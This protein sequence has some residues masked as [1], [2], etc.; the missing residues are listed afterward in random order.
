[1]L[2]PEEHPTFTHPLV[3]RAIYDAMDVARREGLHA[4]AADMLATA[5]AAPARVATHLLAVA[6]RG[7]HAVVASLRAAAREATARGAP[8]AAATY[9]ARALDEPPADADRSAVTLELGLALAHSRPADS[10]P[11]LMQVIDTTDDDELLADAVLALSYV[12]LDSYA[13]VPTIALRAM[14]RIRDE[15][16]RRRVEAHYAMM[17][18]FRPDHYPAA[19]RML[20]GI[21]DRA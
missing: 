5:G 1:M 21:T 7:D 2:S 19:K 12:P 14:D 18:G 8:D 11:H 10:V 13:E 3:R 20:D 9:L 6:P 16:P 4:A 17:G 15:H